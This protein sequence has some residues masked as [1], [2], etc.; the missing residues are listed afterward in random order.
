MPEG[1]RL[2]DGEHR[3]IIAEEI[4]SWTYYAFSACLLFGGDELSIWD[5][6]FS[7][8]K[9]TCFHAPLFDEL[10]DLIMAESRD[11]RTGR[12]GGGEGN[13]VGGP[14]NTWPRKFGCAL[15]FVV[16]ELNG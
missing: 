6:Y 4:G 7:H 13:Q 10:P 8:Q 11:N 1:C 9:H 16:S 15:T 3:V 12:R 14:W 5:S 2:D